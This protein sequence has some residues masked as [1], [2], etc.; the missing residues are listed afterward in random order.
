MTRAE[1]VAAMSDEALGRA[2]A[3]DLGWRVFIQHYVSEPIE[4]WDW[5]NP[6]KRFTVMTRA[7][8]EI[9]LLALERTTGEKGEKP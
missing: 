9:A 5:D 7:A 6:E 3:A 2:L 1:E 8:A 4:S